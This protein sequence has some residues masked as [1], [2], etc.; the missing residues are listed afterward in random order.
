MLR[1]PFSF[2][3]NLSTG[4]KSAAL[5]RRSRF[6]TALVGAGLL[7]TL[8]LAGLLRPDPRG[9]GT[10]QQLGLPPCTLT[11]VAGIPCPACGMTTSWALVTKG[12]PLDALAT[13]VTGTLLAVVALVAGMGATIVAVR[14]KRLAW[15]PGETAAAIGA[16][17]LAGL[18]LVE[19][20]FR[21]FAG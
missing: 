16:L 18:V 8:V 1:L 3:V 10:H 19:W 9:S 20:M 7:G 12:R 2:R 6:L 15:Q 17:A 21:L 14:G 4:K 13:H 5:S 11:V